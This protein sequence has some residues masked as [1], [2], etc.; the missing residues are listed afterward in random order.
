MCALF[1]WKSLWACLFCSDHPVLVLLS[2]LLLS[3]LDN[4]LPLPLPHR[5]N[6]TSMRVVMSMSRTK[7]PAAMPTMAS[8]GVV[9]TGV[10][11]GMPAE[12]IARGDQVSYQYSGS[13]FITDY[14]II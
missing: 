4:G 5:A 9:T 7:E 8:T 1:S 12:Q 6:V 3:L 14:N 10:G 2:T 13:I 11:V